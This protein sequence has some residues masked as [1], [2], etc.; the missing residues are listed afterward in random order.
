MRFVR[1]WRHQ[2]TVGSK[3]LAA[4][5]T[6]WA[7]AATLAAGCKTQSGMPTAPESGAARASVL[8]A[9][10]IDGEALS[11]EP[12]EGGVAS[13]DVD[14]IAKISAKAAQ[15]KWGSVPHVVS[16]PDN[17]G[18][19]VHTMGDARN[20]Y[21]PS[22][23]MW[24]VPDWR[25]P[26]RSTTRSDCLYGH[27]LSSDTVAVM[28][29]DLLWCIRDVS[30]SAVREGYILP[31]GF[32]PLAISHDRSRFL[33]SKEG[34]GYWL[35]NQDTGLLKLSVTYN[36]KSF[37][38]WWAESCRGFIVRG[39]DSIFLVDFD[40]SSRVIVANEMLDKLLGEEFL[41]TEQSGR[42]RLRRINGEWP[43]V[44]ELPVSVGYT[45]YSVRDKLLYVNGFAALGRKETV[46]GIGDGVS[47]FT[48]K[49]RVDNGWPMKVWFRSFAKK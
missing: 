16:S 15:I 13:A 33:L 29:T 20:D 5:G 22:G 8:V 1:L 24:F 10:T 4:I 40:G 27:Y 3:R 2:E 42:S 17:A 25:F 47:D 37:Y 43:I 30:G 26:E 12:R 21:R 45:H 18:M 48:N 35:F 44:G 28:S 7:M 41:L 19:I 14:G 6:S 9:A 31:Q 32:K 34:S 36:D 39:A 23:I 11:F 38:G 46:W 49:Y